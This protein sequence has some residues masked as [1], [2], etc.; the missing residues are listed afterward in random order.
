MTAAH[1]VID[2]GEQQHQGQDNQIRT[3]LAAEIDTHQRGKARNARQ[4]ARAVGESLPFGGD[5][6]EDVRVSKNRQREVWTAQTQ[7]RRNKDRRER[8]ANTTED[9]RGEFRDA[10]PHHAQRRDIRAHADKR[11]V[12][13]TDHAAQVSQQRPS[14]RNAADGECRDDV[15]HQI[16]IAAQQHR[17]TG[18]ERDQCGDWHQPRTFNHCAWSRIARSAKQTVPAGT[19]PWRSGPARPN[20]QAWWSRPRRCRSAARRSARRQ[21]IPFRPAR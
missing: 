3:H 13:E 16:E 17:H 21:S 6:L 7:R 5:D 2:P 4:P 1:Q 8:R 12:A 18:V 11:G 19:A 9:Q 10:E 20:S 15:A 14:E